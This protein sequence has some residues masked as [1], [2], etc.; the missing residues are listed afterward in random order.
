MSQDRNSLAVVT[1]FLDCLCFLSTWELIQVEID[2]V[3]VQL[4]SLAN[5]FSQCLVLT[6]LWI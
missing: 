5:V 3:Q 6:E 2:T 1:P 4:T